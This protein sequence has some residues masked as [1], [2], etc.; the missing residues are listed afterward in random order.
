V[1]A[2][3]QPLRRAT[4][5]ACAA[6]TALSAFV[7]SA[8]AQA[9]VDAELSGRLA[10]V[11]PATGRITVLPEGE[12]RPTEVFAAADCE[13]R[14]E[15]RRLTLTELVIHV[16]RR[17]TIQYQLENDRRIARTITVDPEGA[18]P[19]APATRSSQSR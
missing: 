16:G 9:A 8:R 5:A 14:L 7:A 3:L 19:L 6:L 13:V 1:T 18:Q 12:I 17:V 11:E 10:T 2:S 4:F 15:K